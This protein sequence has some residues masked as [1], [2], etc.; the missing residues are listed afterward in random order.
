MG[1]RIAKA[2]KVP[3]DVSTLVMENAALSQQPALSVCFMTA[4][5]ELLRLERTQEPLTLVYK[6]LGILMKQNLPSRSRVQKP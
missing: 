3:F 6:M 5:E 4:T 1:K 2:S